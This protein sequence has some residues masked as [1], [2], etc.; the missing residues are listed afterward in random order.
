MAIGRR[1][2]EGEGG[3]GIGGSVR[4]GRESAT[5]LSLTAPETL[6]H[7]TR[8]PGRLPGLGRCQRTQKLARG[9]AELLPPG[10]PIPVGQEQKAKCAVFPSAPSP[11]RAWEGCSCSSR[12][13][14]LVAKHKQPKG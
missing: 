1:P 7:T 14:G 3:Q 12:W 10:G 5:L 2:G 4:M 6:P 8:V 11:S 9:Q 13:W